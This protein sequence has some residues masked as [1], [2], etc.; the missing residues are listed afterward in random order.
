MQYFLIENGQQAGPFSL[1][2]LYEK[3]ITAEALVWAEGM[4]DWTPAWKVEELRPILDGTYQ[5]STNVNQANGQQGPQVPPVPPTFNNNVNQFAAQQPTTPLQD[6]P[7]SD[8]K[9]VWY[10]IAACV[11]VVLMIFGCS[12]PGKDDHKK[13]IKNEITGAIDEAT[14]QGGEDNDLFSM[15]IKMFTK[16]VSGP[17]LD[18]ALNSM[19][20][21]HSYLVYSKSTVNIGGENKTV[22]YGFLGKVYTINKDDILKA[23]GKG[24]LN[25]QEKTTT[26]SSEDEAEDN[27]DDKTLQGNSQENDP[28]KSIED[29]INDKVD[30]TV[31]RVTDKVSKKVSDKINEKIDQAT[32][33]STIDKVIDKILSIF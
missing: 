19:L 1:D 21:Y 17:I 16:M 26:E 11:L 22:A 7:K 25:I 33:S 14:N 5:P 23:I 29:K 15:G 31:D 6:A 27:S 4:T 28:S 2:Q 3:K 13:A 9:K 18:G 32:D 12:N 20:D 30:E 10:T 24:G 8:N